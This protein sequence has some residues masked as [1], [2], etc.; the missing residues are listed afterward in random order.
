MSGVWLAGV[1]SCGG[2]EGGG[3]SLPRFSLPRT[4]RVALYI[5]PRFGAVSPSVNLKTETQ[6]NVYRNNKSAEVELSEKATTYQK[7]IYECS[8]TTVPRLLT[9]GI[10]SLRDE[11]LVKERKEREKTKQRDS[12]ATLKY[13][14][15]KII[16]TF[17]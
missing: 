16:P 2:K 3:V 10:L 1:V 13:I 7:N 17:P 8:N 14:G 12:R 11:I 4:C 9:A 5:Q 15:Y 6:N